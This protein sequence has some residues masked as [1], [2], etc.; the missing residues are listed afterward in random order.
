MLE[1][2]SE[3]AKNKLLN[4]VYIDACYYLQSCNENTIK[5]VFFNRDEF[6]IL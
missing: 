1:Y 3:E 6:N 2:Y 5:K 4:F